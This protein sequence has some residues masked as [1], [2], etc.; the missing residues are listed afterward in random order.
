MKLKAAVIVLVATVVACEAR[1]DQ[2]PAPAEGVQDPAAASPGTQQAGAEQITVNLIN[3]DG[4]SAGNATLTQRD[5]GVE[6]AIHVMGIEPG[7]HGF[8]VHETGQCEPPAF[9]S[10]GGHFAP[11][12]RQHGL[13][14]PEGPHAGDLPNLRAA[15]NG[16]ADTTFIAPG[17]TLRAGEP[18]SLLR[19]GGTALVVHAGPDDMRTDPSGE[20]GSRV[21][22]GVIQ[23]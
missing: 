18:T 1:D 23:R 15:E 4:G 12:G 9:T 5:D 3:A 21:A 19:D 17:I 6:I 22:C 16:M 7:L 20:S 14:N 10:A 11:E 13:E 8:H 2:P